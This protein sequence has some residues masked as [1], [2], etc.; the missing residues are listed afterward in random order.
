MCNLCNPLIQVSWNNL[1]VSHQYRTPDN[2][3]GANFTI[4]RLTPTE[5]IIAPQNITISRASFDAAIHYLRHHN[6]YQNNPCRIA[7]NNSPN[8]S[9]PLCS[10]ARGANNNVRSIN[11][12][13]P[14]LAASNIVGINGRRP[15][16]TWIL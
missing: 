8:L 4:V 10:V 5:I 1:A 13:L 6:H 15:N 9:G 11:Y 3:A 7:S 14:V 16:T 2:Q 12:I